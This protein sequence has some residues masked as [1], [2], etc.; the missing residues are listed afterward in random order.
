MPGPMLGNFVCLFK[1]NIY[2]SSKEIQYYSLSNLRKQVQETN[3]T[4]WLSNYRQHLNPG[5]L[6][7]VHV[8]T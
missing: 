4:Y 3:K 7:F 8:H 2:S 5:L 1:L 6:F